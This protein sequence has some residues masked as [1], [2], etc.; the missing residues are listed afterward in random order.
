MPTPCYDLACEAMRRYCDTMR[1]AMEDPCAWAHR[2]AAWRNAAD[3]CMQ[4]AVA[5]MKS[6]TY[7]M[8]DLAKI[9]KN[10]SLLADAEVARKCAERI[11]GQLMIELEREGRLRLDL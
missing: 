2:V 9:V 7:D 4:A 5:E 10:G 6:N 1:K 3:V 11:T 8:K